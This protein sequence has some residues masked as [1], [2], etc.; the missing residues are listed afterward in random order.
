[1]IKLLQTQFFFKFIAIK[2]TLGIYLK[3]DLLPHGQD[4][5]LTFPM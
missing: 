1:M 2:I 4:P 3:K 5:R